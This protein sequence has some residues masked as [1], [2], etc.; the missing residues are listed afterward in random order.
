M[1]AVE[2]VSC[3]KRLD[4]GLG[5]VYAMKYLRNSVSAGCR[6]VEQEVIRQKRMYPDWAKWERRR[7]DGHYTA[8]PVQILK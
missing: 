4:I 2:M 6:S 3:A 7:N 8:E 1:V 5:K